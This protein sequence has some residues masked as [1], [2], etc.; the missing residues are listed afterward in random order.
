KLGAIEAPS[1]QTGRVT[2]TAEDDLLTKEAR[3]SLESAIDHLP[4]KYRSVFVMRSLEDMS[5]AETA[6]CLD[7][8]E[9]TVR[10]RLSRARRMLRRGLYERARAASADTFEFLAE[11]CDRLTANVL[12]RIR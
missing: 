7:L 10:V 8:T 9:D 12:A 6:K 1:R 11:R 2:R 4:E 3:A 5:T